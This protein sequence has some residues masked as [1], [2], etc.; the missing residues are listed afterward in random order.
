VVLAALVFWLA[1]RDHR[2]APLL[3]AGVG[4]YLVLGVSAAHFAPHWSAFSD[5]YADA[6][7]GFLSWAAAAAEVGA[8]AVLAVV[9]VAVL[10]GRR[11][12][13]QVAPG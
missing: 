5:P 10:R 8:A 6:D 1:L 13:G 4:A 2:R 7:L 9:G 12:V 3:A 11:V